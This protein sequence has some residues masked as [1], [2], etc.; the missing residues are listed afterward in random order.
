MLF[1]AFMFL[2]A[3]P[4]R[5]DGPPPF[6]LKE[7]TA[8]WVVHN[9]TYGVLSTTSV[10]LNGTAFGNVQSFVDGDMSFS[11]GIPYFYVSEMDVS[12]E[13]IKANPKV[14]FTVSEVNVGYCAQQKWDP[15]D[16]RCAKVVLTGVMVTIT[17]EEADK[18][19]NA[20]FARHPAMK[21]WPTSH[22]WEIKKLNITDIWMLDFFGG[23][24][25]LDLDAYYKADPLN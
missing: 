21:Y 6:I 20:M 22:S 17:G 7:K 15:E 25:I 9:A 24:S 18:F 14:S 16:P 23:A 13:D 5:A 2:M 3:P 4:A 8:R 12:Q 19:K 1:A 11:S 10:H